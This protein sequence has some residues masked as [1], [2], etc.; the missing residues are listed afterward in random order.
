MNRA[1]AANYLLAAVRSVHVVGR[2]YLAPVKS[3]ALDKA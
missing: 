3:T 1:S 2:K